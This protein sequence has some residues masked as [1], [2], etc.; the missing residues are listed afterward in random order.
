MVILKSDNFQLDQILILFLTARDAVMLEQDLAFE[1][2]LKADREKEEARL[3]EVEERLERAKLEE[4]ARREEEVE[5]EREAA[6][7][8]ARR[9]EAAKRL[10]VEPQ[11]RNPVDSGHFQAFFRAYFCIF[12]LVALGG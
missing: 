7:K 10:P 5:R 12:R 9:Q 1:E 8:E 6:E 3:K 4:A 11:G 2:A